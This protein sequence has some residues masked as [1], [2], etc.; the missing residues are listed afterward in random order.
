MR[1][2]SLIA[3]LL[4]L[5]VNRSPALAAQSTISVDAT[6]KTGTVADGKQK[7]VFG[8]GRAIRISK[9][10]DFKI[11][12]TGL[13]SALYSCTPEQESVADPDRAA[14]L[15]WLKG[16]GPYLLLVAGPSETPPK[17]N[18]LRPADDPRKALLEALA[19]LDSSITGPSGAMGV[20]LVQLEGIDLLVRADRQPDAI[21]VA[22]AKY[23]RAMPASCG[24]G[25]CPS[26]QFVLD[27]LR[28]IQTAANRLRA[29]VKER[30]SVIGTKPD[31]T[32]LRTLAKQLPDAELLATAGAALGDA[33]NIRALVLSVHAWDQ[34]LRLPMLELDCSSVRVGGDSGRKVSL[35]ISPRA[36]PELA[37]VD[38]ARHAF[39]FGFTATADRRARFGAGLALLYAPRASYSAFAASEAN[40]QVTVVEKGVQDFR[41]NYG[42]TLGVALGQPPTGGRPSIFWWPIEAT[43]IPSDNVRALAL[44]TALS[45]GRLKLG[46]GILWARHDVLSEANPV[47]ATLPSADALRTT[48]SFRQP[49]IYLGLSLI[50]LP[51]FLPE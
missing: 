41:I 34:R 26:V 48:T 5:V 39:K 17:L 30:D 25:G 50:G 47:G 4:L 36:V 20:R 42:L 22:R 21:A 11:K 45:V 40:G 7:A 38:L 6:T 28:R 14:I 35:T 16:L 23:E 2:F 31:S 10:R 13:P 8:N 32:E 18:A 37:D 27:Q 29:A 3:G 51:P 49:K 12:V 43:V 9:N 33:D 19:A 46:T 15:T 24:S 44:G 1:P